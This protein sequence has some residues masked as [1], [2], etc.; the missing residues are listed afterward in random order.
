MRKT[1]ARR[2]NNVNTMNGK[3]V[4]VVFYSSTGNTR[5]VAQAIGK[6]LSADVEQIH[7]VKPYQVDIKGKGLGNSVNVSRAALGGMAART[8]PIEAVQRD[9]ADYDL[10]L[11][12]TPVCANSLPAPV[13]AYVEQY[14]PKF[15]EVA[16][17]CT[18]EDPDNE[19]IFEL[20]E[21]ACGKT[22]CTSFPF[23]APKIRADEFH[24]QVEAFIGRL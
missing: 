10:V 1:T 20:L 7:Q 6:A 11:I 4:L 23:H 22:P 14:R 5:K 2:K 8:T 12:G 15:K 24:S 3:S 21:E 19:H 16:F 9:P 18:G 13:R 17:F